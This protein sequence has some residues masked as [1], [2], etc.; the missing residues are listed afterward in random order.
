MKYL[1][2]EKQYIIAMKN[3]PPTYP[4]G[5]AQGLLSAGGNL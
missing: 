5:R 3:D 1:K 2:E 4:Y